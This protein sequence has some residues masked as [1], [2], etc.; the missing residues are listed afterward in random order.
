ML[1]APRGDGGAGALE[2]EAACEFIGEQREIERAAVR[3]KLGGKSGGL[4]RP[5]C[6][7]IAAAGLRSED[8]RI[9]WRR[10]QSWERLISR[11]AQAPWASQ[12]PALKSA[13]TE[14]MKVEGRRWQSC[15]LIIATMT[16]RGRASQS[17]ERPDLPVQFCSN[18]D[19]QIQTLHRAHHDTP[20][21]TKK[22]PGRHWAVGRFRDSLS[23]K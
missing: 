2:V 8:P 21:P 4:G 10:K 1:A 23:R 15:F 3:E 6:G 5:R 14:A 11:R 22:T 13:R 12:R 20:F 7:V 9:G 16:A 17:G 18:P 19:T